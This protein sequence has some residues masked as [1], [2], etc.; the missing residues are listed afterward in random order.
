MSIIKYNFGIGWLTFNNK[1]I[2]YLIKKVSK[3]TGNVLLFMLDIW[4]GTS[5]KL[6]NCDLTFIETLFLFKNGILFVLK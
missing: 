4:K 6:R 3:V 5:F 2:I 1:D